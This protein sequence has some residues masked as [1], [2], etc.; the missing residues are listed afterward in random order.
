MSNVILIENEEHLNKIISENQ[1]V[2]VD[3][4]AEWCGPCKML[5]PVLDEVSTEMNDVIICKVDVDDNTNIA[6]ENNVRGIPTVLYYKN[7]EKVGT[8]S[9][10]VPK[11]QFMQTLR[12]NLKLN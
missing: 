8:K 9:G 12:E 7:G 11:P 10:Y 1:N 4:F 5:L 6:S 3:F 2:V